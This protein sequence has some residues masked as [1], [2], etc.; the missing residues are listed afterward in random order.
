MSRPLAAIVFRK[1]AYGRGEQ[2]WFERVIEVA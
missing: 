1:M 2:R